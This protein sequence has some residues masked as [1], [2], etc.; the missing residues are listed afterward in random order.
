M[1][2]PV[3]SMVQ[4]SHAEMPL[5][6]LLILARE[7]QE[8]SVED[9]ANRLRLS[10]RQIMALENNNF[11]ALPEPMI[12]R[13]FIRN[14]ARLL[15]IDP[16]PLLQAYSAHVPSNNPYAI[17]IPSANILIS[18]KG[19]RPWLAY[20][21]ASLVISIL[22]AGWMIYTEYNPQ[23]SVHKLA[24]LAQTTSHKPATENTPPQTVAEPLPVPA[25][26]AAERAE[27]TNTTD[28]VLPAAEQLPEQAAVAKTEAPKVS[29]VPNTGSTQAS[30]NVSAAGRLKFTFSESSWVR[31]SDRDGK[32]ILNK[33]KPAGSQEIIEGLPP[34][35]VVVGNATGSQL[36]FNDKP[37]DLA[38]YTKL[39]VAHIT[40]E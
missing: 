12:T 22:L 18:G 37:V 10:P 1:N 11:S 13:G 2:D 26:P 25:L 20:M 32:E 27:Q 31:V 34:F 15:R 23:Q 19:K 29:S 6:S 17:T 4:D 24:S 30:A 9:V 40:L 7:E 14:Y 39:N 38:P 33:T 21:V 5:G 35:K 36:V 8:L 16:E 28:I 3:D